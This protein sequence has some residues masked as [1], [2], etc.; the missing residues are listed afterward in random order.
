VKTIELS[1]WSS[2]LLIGHFLLFMVT[3]PVLVPYMD[4]IHAM[5]LFWL[6]PSK[7]IR[8]PLYSI[9]QKRTRRWIVMKY[10]ALYI[11]VLIV[12]AALIVI[13]ECPL[14]FHDSNQKLTCRA[15]S[16]GIPQGDQ[17][18]LF[19]MSE[20]LTA[21]LLGHF[22]LIYHHHHRRYNSR[23]DHSDSAPT[24]C[25]TLSRVHL[26]Y[27]TMHLFN[28]LNEFFSL[29]SDTQALTWVNMR[30]N[31]VDGSSVRSEDKQVP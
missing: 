7:Q 6:R 30:T 17:G 18:Q 24:T 19:H 26:S 29:Q 11:T 12:F 23:F 4:R 15:R 3:L 10:G 28:D 13:R 8:A 14:T 27:P 20:S 22:L 31:L 9:K 25:L 16:R 21:Y 2:D 1:L 5:L